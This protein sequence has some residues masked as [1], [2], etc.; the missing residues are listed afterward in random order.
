MRR[1]LDVA[2]LAPAAALLLAGAIAVAS[3]QVAL[4]VWRLAR[5]RPPPWVR[6]VQELIDEDQQGRGYP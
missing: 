1:F 5:R 6:R 3:A 4:D 2:V